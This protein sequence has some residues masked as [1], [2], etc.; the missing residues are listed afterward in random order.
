MKIKMLVAIAFSIGAMAF[1]QRDGHRGQR[2]EYHQD[3]TAEQL[4]TLKTKKMTLALD[5]NQEQQQAIFEFNKANA[6]FRKGKMEDRKAQ[7]D[8]GERSGPTTEERYSMENARLDRMIAQQQKLKKILT[9]EQ[10]D[11]WKK[12]QMHKH[13]HNSRNRLR[14]GRRGK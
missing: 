8:T 7:R 14:E 1:A 2:G 3:L 10:F 9:D 6:E 13:S 5:L 11:Q 4:A 12:M